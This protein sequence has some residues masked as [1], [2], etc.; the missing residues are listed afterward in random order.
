MDRRNE[1]GA[2]ETTSHCQ[3]NRTKARGVLGKRSGPGQAAVPKGEMPLTLYHPLYPIISTP[4]HTHS[5][6]HPPSI[7]AVPK[8]RMP[9]LYH[10]CPLKQYYPPSIISYTPSITAVPKGCPPTSSRRHIY[11]PIITSL[12]NSC[13]WHILITSSF[14]NP[15]SAIIPTHSPSITIPT[16]HQ[17]VGG[18]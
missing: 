3:Q 9:T 12:H 15:L 10:T 2:N 4:Y 7:T 5:L 17:G 8:G 6:S 14:V 13:Q 1:E 18:L 11:E 16:V